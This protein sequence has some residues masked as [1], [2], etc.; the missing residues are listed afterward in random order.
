MKR[1]TPRAAGTLLLRRPPEPHRA[2]AGGRG[3]PDGLVPPWTGLP[4]RRRREIGCS[5]RRGRIQIDTRSLLYRAGPY[6]VSRNGLGGT[7]VRSC[8]SGR[9][10]GCRARGRTRVVQRGVFPDASVPSARSSGGGSDEPWARAAGD[11]GTTC[12]AGSRRPVSPDRGPD[13]RDRP[14]E[15][16]SD[17]HPEEGRLAAADRGEAAQRS[18]GR[19]RRRPRR[20]RRQHRQAGHD[21]G[22]RAGQPQGRHP[23]RAGRR[24]PGHRRLGRRQRRARPGAADRGRVAGRQGRRPARRRRRAGDARQ[25]GRPRRPGVQG[26]ARHPH[27]RRARPGQGSAGRG[28]GGDH[29]RGH[30][31]L[32]GQRGR[33]GPRC[34]RGPPAVQGDRHRRHRRRA[35]RRRRLAGGLDRRPATCRPTR[36][37][38]PARRA[39][40]TRAPR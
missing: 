15:A 23:G 17:R 18:A 24:R 28:A 1:P 20:D 37:C 14:G 16:R 30:P 38:C 4:S 2:P 33:Q 11:R 34:R 7:R 31:G 8:A 21:R 25:R 22:R 26:P 5:R 36:G 35:L 3:A 27:L 12:P 29:R 32:G 40:A 9:V 6:W 39:T 10:W 19:R 13:R